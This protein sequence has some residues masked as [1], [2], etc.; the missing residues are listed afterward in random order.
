MFHCS[1]DIFNTTLHIYEKLDLIKGKICN[2]SHNE[3]LEHFDSLEFLELMNTNSVNLENYKKFKYNITDVIELKIK[4]QIT[5]NNHSSCLQLKD[6]FFNDLIY[7]MQK[8]TKAFWFE[9]IFLFVLNFMFFLPLPTKLLNYSFVYLKPR[10]M[11]LF[12]VLIQVLYTLFLIFEIGFSNYGNITT[13]IDKINDF[14]ANNCVDDNF[15][16]LL[17]LII[18]YWTSMNKEIKY[19]FLAFLSLW[20]VLINGYLYIFKPY[21]LHIIKYRVT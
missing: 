9:M 2:F 3:A 17:T 18:E 4:T 16:N 7:K 14:I 6:Y 1:H 8:F 10:N 21:K 12:I 15:K 11:C 20:I 13:E 5:L 19:H